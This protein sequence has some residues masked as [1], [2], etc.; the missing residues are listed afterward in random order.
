MR[1]APP[2]AE[3][4]PPGCGKGRARRGSRPA[5]RRAPAATAAT[6][7]APPAPPRSAAADPPAARRARIAAAPGSGSSP[8]HQ[9]VEDLFQRLVGGADLAQAHA[10]VAGQPWQLGGE[11]LDRAGARPQRVALDL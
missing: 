5:P 1:S 8:P 9:V 6:A 10:R 7:A 2:G 11:R 4:E 3:T